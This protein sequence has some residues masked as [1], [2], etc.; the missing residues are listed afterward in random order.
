MKNQPTPE[1]KPLTIK[2]LEIL[3]KPESKSQDT[4]EKEVR[5]SMCEYWYQEGTKEGMDSIKEMLI[6]IEEAEKNVKQKLGKELW[7]W[8]HANKPY[9]DIE[10]CIERLT[11]VKNPK[12]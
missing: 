1:S 4:S 3:D 12:N 10:D 2:D 8:F 9:E 7:K 11:G 6:S 5:D